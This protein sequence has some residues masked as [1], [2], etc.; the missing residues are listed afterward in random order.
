M[1][2]LLKQ[3]LYNLLSHNQISPYSSVQ[4][5]QIQVTS[6]ILAYFQLNSGLFIQQQITKIVISSTV[7]RRKPQ[8]SRDSLRGIIFLW[9]EFFHRKKPTGVE[10]KE[11]RNE[12]DRTL[13]TTQNTDWG[14]EKV[15]VSLSRIQTGTQFHRREA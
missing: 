3:Q 15:R 10:G 5:N 6:V 9:S 1:W 13:E 14:K 7:L 8:Q 12:K 4:L 11:T 2:T